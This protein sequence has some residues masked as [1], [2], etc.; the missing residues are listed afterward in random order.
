MDGEQLKKALADS[1]ISISEAARKLG[2]PQS[3]L[4][5]ALQ[6]DDVRTGL[7]EGIASLCGRTPAS[8]YTG[9]NSAIAVAN[10]AQSQ[11]T[12][13]VQCDAGIAALSKQLDVKDSQIGELFDQ[14]KRRDELT[15]NLT[16]IIKSLNGI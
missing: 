4:S 5:A 8:F 2:I 13:N 10:G 11:A 16:T 6:N 12:S 1:K 14:I 15:Q 3:T 7:L 9:D